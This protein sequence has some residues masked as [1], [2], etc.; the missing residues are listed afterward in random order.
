MKADLLG[1]GSTLID[2]AELWHNVPLRNSDRNKYEIGTAKA[3]MTGNFLYG[4]EIIT[5]TR[6]RE[7]FPK[8]SVRDFWTRKSAKSSTQHY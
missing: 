7:T 2:I 5:V 4:V 1:L 6:V 8:N 3:N